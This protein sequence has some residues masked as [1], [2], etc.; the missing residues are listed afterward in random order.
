MSAKYPVSPVVQLVDNRTRDLDV[1]TL[2]AHHL[3][4]RG[5]PCLLE[6]LEA[7]R[8][9]VAA[10]RPSMI[11]FNHLFA[12]HLVNWSRR[13][14]EI[15]VQTAVLTNEGMLPSE[16]A[17]RFQSG[18]YHRAGHVD[19]FFC[20][21]SAHRKMIEEESA[22]PNARVETI[23][24]PR[25]D[26]YFEPWANIVRQQDDNMRQRPRILFCTNTGLAKF[27]D[28]PREHGDRHFAAWVNYQKN[29][30]DPWARVETQWHARQKALKFA[31][32]LAATG[33][34]E[35]V[36]RP[37]P[38]ES[39]TFYR[40]WYEGLPESLRANMQ[41]D[42]SSNI[43]KLILNCDLV[44]SE[45]GCT[46]GVESWIARKPTIGMSLYRNSPLYFA[47][48]AKCHVSCDDPARLP[49]LVQEQLA[50]PVS[51]EL[52]TLRKEH[53]AKWCDDQDGRSCERIA[54][55]IADTVA[56]KRPA[57][58]SKLDVNDYRR[59]AK[60]RGYGRLGLPYQFDPLLKI[61]RSV[62]GERY[63]MKDLAYRKSIRPK[64]VMQARQRLEIALSKA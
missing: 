27:R 15:G 41:I 51:E 22:Y 50:N 43:T 9:V 17:R 23:G 48:R 3:R 45:E 49:A 56:A 11:V 59:A 7:F 38:A 47:E 8:A 21:N 12:S 58:W 24:V 64:D 36:F 6:P 44:I 2:I 63:A 30:G 5:V 26:F 29:Y 61:K 46:T 10:H 19:L 34:Y 54:T 35:I 42:K 31:E 14:H 16:E 4:Q 55:A 32:T 60:L 62:F 37:H 1:A 39:E 28:L 40:Q 57:D 20:W 53:I 52:R 13:L 25:F 18:G 33:K